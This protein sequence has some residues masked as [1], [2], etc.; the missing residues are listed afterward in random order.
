[1]GVNPLEPTTLPPAPQKSADLDLLL[2]LL[3]KLGGGGHIFTQQKMRPIRVQAG[4]ETMDCLKK[5]IPTVVGGS[6]GLGQQY[7]KG[8]EAISRVGVEELL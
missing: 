7:K 3:G 2:H 5:K 1:M 6:P 8:Q 4:P